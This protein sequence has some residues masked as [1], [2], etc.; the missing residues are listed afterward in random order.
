MALLHEELTDKILEAFFNVYNELGFGFLESVYE[1]AMMKELKDIGVEC[2]SQVPINV[3][4]KEEKMGI[5]YADILVEDLVILELK[6]TSLVEK[7]TYQLLNY[8]K[9]T[10]IEVGMLLSF[11]KEA[12]FKRKLFMNTKK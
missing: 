8:L 12:Q 9:A 10:D 6:A 4:Y 3:F 11:G 5:F 2:Q 1:N 7:F